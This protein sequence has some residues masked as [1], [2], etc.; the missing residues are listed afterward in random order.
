MARFED[1]E[2]GHGVCEGRCN[3]SWHMVYL[4]SRY[5]FIPDKLSELLGTSGGAWVHYADRIDPESGSA[6]YIYHLI[7]AGTFDLP[8]LRERMEEIEAQVQ[9]MKDLHRPLEWL[10]EEP[11]ESAGC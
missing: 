2:F 9:A 11:C 3:Y 8:K 1:H 4:S 6:K 10:E 7:A 5:K